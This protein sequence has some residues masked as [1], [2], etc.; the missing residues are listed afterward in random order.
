MVFGRA[1]GR[2]HPC[3]AGVIWGRPSQLLAAVVASLAG[4]RGV[5]AQGEPLVPLGTTSYAEPLAWTAVALLIV[6]A[7]R[8][9]MHGIG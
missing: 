5:M 3:P 7:G 4:I 8:K 1:P 2:R 9:D 6:L